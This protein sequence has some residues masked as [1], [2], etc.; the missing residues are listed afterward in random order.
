MGPAGCAVEEPRLQEHGV[1]VESVLNGNTIQ[2]ALS[3]RL[4][5]LQGRKDSERAWV[6]ARR[7]GGSP[8]GA[9]VRETAG[10]ASGRRAGRGGSAPT[11]PFPS[12]G[13]PVPPWVL[14]PLSRVPL[15][16]PLPARLRASVLLSLGL[17]TRDLLCV[18]VL[19]FCPASLI[20]SSKISCP[21]SHGALV[22]L[23]LS[24]C[25][26]GGL[27]ISP[28]S[29]SPGF[30]RLPG[31]CPPGSAS[32]PLGLSLQRLN[33][34]VSTCFTLPQGAGLQMPKVLGCLFPVR[35]IKV[36]PLCS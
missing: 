33:E 28:G 30:V 35:P 4:H 6:E 1:A 25:P 15:Q 5:Q 24:L 27:S 32:A 7:P 26:F 9:P 3:R 21:L 13:L 10:L 12:L 16:R 8:L 20:S 14:A 36:L 31:V 17:S 19:P 23:S 18:S 2:S 22:P 34:C 11:L 29:L